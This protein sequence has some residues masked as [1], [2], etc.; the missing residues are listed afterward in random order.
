MPF[1]TSRPRFAS[2]SWQYLP[3]QFSAGKASTKT[4]DLQKS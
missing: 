1:A 4:A 3:R 2:V